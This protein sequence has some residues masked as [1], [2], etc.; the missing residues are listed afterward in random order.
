MYSMTPKL[1]NLFCIRVYNKRKKR[2]SHTLRVLK[3]LFTSIPIPVN[4]YNFLKKHHN[5]YRYALVP[6]V[7]DLYRFIIDLYSLT[8]RQ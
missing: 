7:L 4:P 1:F 3:L 5:R 8:K 2:V 6:S